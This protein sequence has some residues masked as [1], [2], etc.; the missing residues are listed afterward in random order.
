[1]VLAVVWPGGLMAASFTIA[2][3]LEQFRPHVERRLE[4]DVERVDAVWPPERLALLGFK[5]ERVLEVWLPA[6]SAKWVCVR[7]YPVL[8]ASGG[9]GP[10]LR[11]GDLQ[12]PEGIYGLEYLNPNSRFHLSMKVSYPNAWDRARAR[13]DGRTRLG[14]DIMI[15]GRDVSIG[16][17]A[18]G[19]EAVEELFVMA[20]LAGVA[21]AEVLL[22]P[23]D[24]RVRSLPRGVRIPPWM[25]EVYEELKAELDRFR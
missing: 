24:F 6:K 20:A 12:V 8:A 25:T 14:G 19:D 18:V 23:V 11:E 2:D 10:K 22:C 9:L 16:C 13:E 5:Q 15:H 3:R 4:A 21:N 1:M 7:S 17:L